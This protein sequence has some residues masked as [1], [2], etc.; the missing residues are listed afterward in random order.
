MLDTSTEQQMVELLGHMWTRLQNLATSINSID[1][2]ALVQSDIIEL[3][4]IENIS[5]GLAYSVLEMKATID[6][7]EEMPPELVDHFHFLIQNHCDEC[8]TA[9]S[10]VLK[11]QSGTPRQPVKI[12]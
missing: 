7:G 4:A 8:A 5:A 3:E 10:I 6:E 2:E 9:I 12:A 11:E 1:R